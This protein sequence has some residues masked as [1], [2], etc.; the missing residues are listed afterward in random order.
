MKVSALDKE[1][2]VKSINPKKQQELF[3]IAMSCYPDADDKGE[4]IR[5]QTPSEKKMLNDIYFECVE[6]S[7]VEPPKSIIDRLTLGISIMSAYF[8]LDK[9]K[10]SEPE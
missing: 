5:E 8:D 6:L 4:Y 9:K 1:W 2:E 10:L 3:S 7:G